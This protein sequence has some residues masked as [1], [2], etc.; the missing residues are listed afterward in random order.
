MCVC[1]A[2]L[3]CEIARAVRADDPSGVRAALRRGG[4]PHRGLPGPA[5]VGVS[6]PQ[7]AAGLDANVPPHRESASRGEWERHG[8]DEP[9]ARSRGRRRARGGRLDPDG[10]E[11]ALPA[12]RGLDGAAARR[13]N[14]RRGRPRSRARRGRPRRRARPRRAG[15]APVRAGGQPRPRPRDQHVA[16][17]R[18]RRRLRRQRRGDR[19]A[20][21]HAARHRRDGPS[22]SWARPRARVAG[23]ASWRATATTLP[24]SRGPRRG[25]RTSTCPRTSSASAPS[26]TG[27]SPDSER[28]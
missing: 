18:H 16:G 17:S 4:P 10:R 23:S 3:H 28:S 26:W 25:S 2:P 12:A 15:G 19:A 5:R 14:R 13:R 21:G 22:W 20:R 11:Q 8:R 9:W 24:S 27:A 6:R 1:R 7:R